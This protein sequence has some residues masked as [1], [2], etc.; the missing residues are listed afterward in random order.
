MSAYSGFT[1]TSYGAQG[2]DDSGGFFAGG[3]QQG[4]QGGAGGK[5]YQ[6]ESLRPVTIKQILDAEE[7]YAGADF[8]IDGSPVTQITFVGQIRKIQP[9]PTNITLNIDDGTGMIEVKKWIDVDKQDDADAG[10][11]L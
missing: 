10:F 2:G 11:E 6:D 1:K 9:Q 5:S 8:K 3:S 7:A 4:S